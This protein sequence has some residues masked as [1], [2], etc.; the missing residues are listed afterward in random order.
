MLRN[1]TDDSLAKLLRALGRLRQHVRYGKRARML[2]RL[3]SNA[4]DEA[5]VRFYGRAA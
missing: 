2:A 3:D 4:C 1:M 5:D